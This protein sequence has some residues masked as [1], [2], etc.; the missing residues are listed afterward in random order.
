MLTRFGLVE[1][2]LSHKQ[3]AW[4]ALRPG[5]GILEANEGYESLPTDLRN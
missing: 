2:K 1:V 3:S 4:A 5:R